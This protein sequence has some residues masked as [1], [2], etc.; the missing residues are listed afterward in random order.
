[1][2][3]TVLARVAIILLLIDRPM[4]FSQSTHA[5]CITYTRTTAKVTGT[6][7]LFTCSVSQ[8]RRVTERGYAS[9][10]CLFLLDIQMYYLPLA[11]AVLCARCIL[12]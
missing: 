12:S 9:L 6:I 11:M 5:N 10:F 2:F 3:Q 7:A 1:M 4:N 8:V